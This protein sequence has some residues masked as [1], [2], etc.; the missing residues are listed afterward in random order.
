[1]NENILHQENNNGIILNQGNGNEISHNKKLA[2]II[3]FYCLY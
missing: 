2:K 1:M 3:A